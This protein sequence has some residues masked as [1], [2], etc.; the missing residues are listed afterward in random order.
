MLWACENEQKIK[1][2]WKKIVDNFN[3]TAMAAIQFLKNLHKLA[4]FAIEEHVRDRS[5]VYIYPSPFSMC[6]AIADQ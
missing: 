6:I 5:K 1:N 4:K 3:T 2:F